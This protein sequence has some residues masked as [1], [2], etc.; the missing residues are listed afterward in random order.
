MSLETAFEIR[1]QDRTNEELI[2]MYKEQKL[3]ECFTEIVKR[4]HRPLFAFILRSI[5]Y[6]QVQDVQQEVWMGLAQS[7]DSYDNNRGILNW[8]YSIAQNKV[9]DQHRKNKRKKRQMFS[10]HME[11]G[12]YSI[13]DVQDKH[14]SSPITRLEQLETLQ[15]IHQLVSSLTEKRRNIFVLMMDGKDNREIARE[16]GI[17]KQ[18][19][20]TALCYT[21]RQIKKRLLKKEHSH[22]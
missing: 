14:T 10:S 2:T 20:A 3:D 5:P 9:A 22:L 16:L 13:E 4:F 7:I 12:T 19:I 8:L 15:Q 18:T 11:S 21:R 1:V 17:E 6:D